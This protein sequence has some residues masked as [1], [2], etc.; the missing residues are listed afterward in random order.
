MG[1][2]P[3]AVQTDVNTQDNISDLQDLTDA[4]GVGQERGNFAPE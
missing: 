4:Q 1:S 2:G 3:Q